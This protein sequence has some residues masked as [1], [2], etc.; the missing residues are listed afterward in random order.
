MI[1]ILAVLSQFA[2]FCRETCSVAI[3]A[4]F[5]WRKIQPTFLSV[6]KNDKFKVCSQKSQPTSERC[7]SIFLRGKNKRFDPKKNLL[8]LIYSIRFKNNIFFPSQK[9]AYVM[10]MACVSDGQMDILLVS[11]NTYLKNI[12]TIWSQCKTN[13]WQFVKTYP[14]RR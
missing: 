11:G 7:P 13:K 10:D 5:M 12:F 9:R 14:V 4:H 1:I 3:Y 2:L 8:M 6:G